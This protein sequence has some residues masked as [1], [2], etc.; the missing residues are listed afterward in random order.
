MESLV[1]EPSEEYLAKHSRAFDFSVHPGK[2]SQ[3][4]STPM[5]RMESAMRVR[6]TALLT[7]GC[8]C[9]PLEVAT[10]TL[11]RRIIGGNVTVSLQCDACGR[12]LGSA[13]SR[14]AHFN[15]QDYPPWDAALHE[16]YSELQRAYYENIRKQRESQFPT[17]PD[18]AERSAE[19]A[20][21]CRTSPEWAETV[22]KIAWRSR[23]HC[24]ACLSAPS[25]VVH[26]LTYEFGK[27][28]PAW[29]LKAVCRRCHER[30]HSADDDWCDVGMARS[31][32]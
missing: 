9:N 30:M 5:P 18:Y 28:P 26:H 19:Y 1:K 15:F 12:A 32:E 20:E 10:A 17:F 31:E 24:E 11:K 21:W 7:E 22:K 23:G 16:A 2:R 8:D 27:L 13:M 4:L 6:V 3:L 29:H 25:E 14:K